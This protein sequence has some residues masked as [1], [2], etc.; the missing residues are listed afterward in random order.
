[1]TA[2]NVNIQT[3][4]TVG[5]IPYLT[6]TRPDDNVSTNGHK[7]QILKI[8][9]SSTVT[10]MRLLTLYLVT[11]ELSVSHHSKQAME[12]LKLFE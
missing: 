7:M 5:F 9:V 12:T 11:I 3:A 6:D 2:V 10:W 4:Q 8:C 1:V